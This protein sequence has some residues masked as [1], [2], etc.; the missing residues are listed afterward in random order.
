MKDIM[1]TPIKKV[2]CSI[3]D[4]SVQEAINRGAERDGATNPHIP[5]IKKINAE[6]EMFRAVQGGEEVKCPHCN[7]GALNKHGYVIECDNEKCDAKWT[8][9]FI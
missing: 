1:K 7:L 5:I 8:L 6:M 3:A 2:P 9:D 4:E